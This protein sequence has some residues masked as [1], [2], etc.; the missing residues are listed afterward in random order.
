MVTIITLAGS[1]HKLWSWFFNQNSI[2]FFRPW[3][4][5]YMYVRILFFNLL[6]TCIHMLGFFFV[7]HT[8]TSFVEWKKNH[9]YRGINLEMTHARYTWLLT[10]SAVPRILLGHHYGTSRWSHVTLEGAMSPSLENK[11]LKFMCSW[12]N[13][14]T[15]LEAVFGYL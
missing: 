11:S 8:H 1:T 9:I 4:S 3:F 12:G 2:L 14:C 13:L 5:L 6:W 7:S 15:E 10:H